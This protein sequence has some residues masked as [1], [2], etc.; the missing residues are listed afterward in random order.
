MS[1]FCFA[2]KR[3]LAKLTLLFASKRK[4]VCFSFA[5][6]CFEQKNDIFTPGLPGVA[7]TTAR[8][9]APVMMSVGG[10]GAVPQPLSRMLHTPSRVFSCTGPDTTDQD[11]WDWTAAQPIK[12]QITGRDIIGHLS[13]LAK[14][15]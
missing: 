5:Y 6:F 9:P 15:K 4:N 12:E 3:K 2:S 13:C 10:R 11:A 8:P 7:A 1:T 14:T